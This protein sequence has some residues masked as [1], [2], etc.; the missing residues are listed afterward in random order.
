[1]AAALLS[2][3]GGGSS[4]LTTTDPITPTQERGDLVSSSLISTIQSILLPY[5]VNSYK[6]VYYTVGTNGDILKASGL[7]SIPVKGANAKS[8]L[9]SYQHGTIFL[10]SRAPS[11]DASSIEG[12]ATLSGNGYIV[13]SPDFLGYAESTQVIHPYIHRESLASASIDML[14]A[15]Q[16]YLANNNIATNDQLFLVGYSEGG[17]ATMAMQKELQENFSSEYTVTASAPG[18]GPFHLSET[19]KILANKVTNED[20]SYLSFVIKTYDETYGLN[21]IDEI[22]QAPYRTIINTYFDSTYSSGEIDAALSHTTSALFEPTFLSLL[23]GDGAHV[24]KD[25]LAE[26]NIYD[27]APT[28]PTRLYHGPLDEVVPYENASIAYQTMDANGAT[29]VSL[30]ICPLSTHVLCAG[31]YILDTLSFFSSRVEDL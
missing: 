13:S 19:A 26:N 15:S 28:A 24:L 8:P 3:C 31:T 22:Y 10:D 14:K 21:K 9:L 2:A 27:W 12:I 16:Q 6:I 23:R 29:D 20:P 1:M 11:V 5:S 4:S 18:A 30:G 25:K 7:L 17:Y